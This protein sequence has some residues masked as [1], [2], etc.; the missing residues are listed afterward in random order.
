MRLGLWDFLAAR[1]SIQSQL[2]LNQ[3]IRR[4]GFVS[5]VTVRERDLDQMI[6]ALP[7]R[8]SAQS[9]GVRDDFSGIL[10]KWRGGKLWR[11]KRE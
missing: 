5:D 3:P 10:D 9:Y 4:L 1:H 8:R 11:T 2:T 7:R 6:L